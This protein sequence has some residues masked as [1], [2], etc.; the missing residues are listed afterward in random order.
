MTRIIFILFAFELPKEG[1]SFLFVGWFIS[2]VSQKQV[3][4]I[5]TATVEDVLRGK[6]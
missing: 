1:F 6:C 4:G 5:V 2:G 3:N